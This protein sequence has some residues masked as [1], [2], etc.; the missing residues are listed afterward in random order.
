MEKQLL[1]PKE[2]PIS[3]DEENSE[4][5]FKVWLRTVEDFIEALSEARQDDAPKINKK[6]IIISCLSPNV[7][8]YVEESESHKNV[9]EVLRRT[10][11]KTTNNVYARHLLVSRRQRPDKSISEYLQVLKTLAKD[12]TFTNVTAQEFS[13]QLTRDSFINGLSSAFIRQ[14]LL[15]NAE[16]TLDRAYELADNLDRACRHALATERSQ[17]GAS[18]TKV[19][20]IQST[21]SPHDKFSLELN[22]HLLAATKTTTKWRKRNSCYFCGGPYRFN[23][24]ECPT[25]N[26]VCHGC[27]KSGHYQKAC[28]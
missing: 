8:P 2:L 14:R 18:V 11:V 28:R 23:R 24:S 4:R 27:G 6:R 20:D 25:K 9:V 12:C 10:F 26:A 22:E 15:Q 7:Y 1:L 21:S 17:P 19:A 16:L 3:P 5:I 13:E